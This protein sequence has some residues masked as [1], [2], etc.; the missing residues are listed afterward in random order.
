[1]D[2][3]QEKTRIAPNDSSD[4]DGTHIEVDSSKETVIGTSSNDDFLLQETNLGPAGSEAPNATVIEA[5]SVTTG[6]K[7]SSELP[8]A[9]LGDYRLIK[10]L[11][12]G[13]MGEVFLAEH[14]KLERKVAIKTL[15]PELARDKPFVDRFYREANL[16]ARLDHPNVVRCDTVGDDEATG[17]QYVTIEFIDGQSLQDWFDQQGTID[18]RDAM[19]IAIKVS[20]ALAYAHSVGLIHRDIKPD[21][22]LISK[23]GDVKVSDLGLAKALDERV[24]M[25][26]SGFGMG[27]PLYMPPEQARNAKHVDHRADIYALGTSLYYIL[28]GK[29]PFGGQ[30]T[31]ELLQSKEEGFFKPIRKFDPN[32]P[33]RLDLVLDKMMAA[34]ADHRYATLQDVISDLKSLGLHQE[35]PQFLKGKPQQTPAPG[36]TAIAPKSTRENSVTTQTHVK[37]STSHMEAES[38]PVWTVCYKGKDKKV[39]FE[40]LTTTELRT[41]LSQQKIP[42]GAEVQAPGETRFRSVSQCPEFQAVTT[43]MTAIKMTHQAMKEQEKQ[44]RNRIEQE[45]KG[46]VYEQTWFLAI[47]ILIVAVGLTWLLWC[48]ATVS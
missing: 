8:A 30:T 21:I 42:S 9:K 33:E 29:P 25:T 34:K 32:L 38:A 17:I 43:Q 39:A 24:S 11:G 2:S 40:K 15:K 18:V 19:T 4:L 27:T 47:V 22:I 35:R 6:K 46:P 5:E 16:M 3:S 48:L 14:V 36:N 12:Q 41:A 1:M 31:I 28:T 37:R 45:S 20:E 7:S 44:T 13:G 26:Q 23:N 10:K